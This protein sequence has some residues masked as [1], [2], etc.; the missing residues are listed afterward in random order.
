[1]THGAWEIVGQEDR[2]LPLGKSLGEAV[3]GLVRHRWPNNAAKQIARTWDLDPK[4]AKNV[5]QSGHVS[6][7][8]LTKAVRAEG[9]AF[10]SAL[11]E[12]LTGESFAQYLHR[13]TEAEANAQKEREHHRD[14][15]VRLEA[16]A[17]DLSAVLERK[18]A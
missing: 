14:N 10:L 5:V 11:G 16:R 3:A 7:R 4:T 17:R 13:I 8:T 15:V 18:R 9:W 12:E 2:R 1:M 6:E